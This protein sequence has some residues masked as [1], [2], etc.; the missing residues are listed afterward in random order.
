[1]S[2]KTGVCAKFLPPLP[3]IPSVSA[4]VTVS[5]GA[6][7]FKWESHPDRSLNDGTLF[8]ANN[9]TDSETT[10]A[11]DLSKW[12]TA[13]P[14]PTKPPTGNDP[15]IDAA[16]DVWTTSSG[17]SG[18]EYVVAR[19]V[20]N[21]KVP[22]TTASGI[23][24]TTAA[25]LRAGTWDF[26]DSWA[27]PANESG[28]GPTIAFDQGGT[29]LWLAASSGN[30]IY[31]SNLNLLFDSTLS[32]DPY[33][34]LK[35][36]PAG[37]RP[38]LYLFPDCKTGNPGGSQCK[39]Y[40]DFPIPPSYGGNGQK[41]DFVDVLADLGGSSTSH[42]TVVVNP[43]TH[44]AL[45][46]FIKDDGSVLVRAV[47]PS[48]AITQTWT[49]GNV[50]QIKGNT[51]CINSS[52]D[53]APDL[54]C[55]GNRLLC[56]DPAT[57]PPPVPG[58]ASTQSCNRY[59]PRVQLDIAGYHGEEPM[60]LLYA[61][62]DQEFVAQIKTP[63]GTTGMARRF[64]AAMAVVDVTTESKTQAKVITDEPGNKGDQT[65]SSTP[66][67]SRFANTVGWFYFYGS[68]NNKFVSLNASVG[69]GSDPAGLQPVQVSP[70]MPNLSTGDNL[71]Q[72]LGGLPG[73]ELLATWPQVVSSC[74][75]IRG[76]RVLP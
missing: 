16:G 56:P 53:I 14:V 54:S 28:D 64:K 49:L 40:A 60:C 34:K 26:P 10:W 24:A 42:T 58:K 6:A 30:R 3:T 18:L 38:H 70:T 55:G 8:Q 46:S 4:D 68:G 35:T 69:S 11:T 66:V 32:P 47:D 27:I 12:S 51:G 15:T 37:G 7:C 19:T 75:I 71:S 33:H 39:R 74:Q 43:C 45:V 50:G 57:V 73:G 59:V 5:A 67:V 36:P 2:C 29:S 76:A 1:M 17:Y 13:F 72:L 23:A 63:N 65:W 20:A 41:V 21:V 62:W 61:G 22:Y 48:G 44:H 9:G 31:D 52:G 25:H